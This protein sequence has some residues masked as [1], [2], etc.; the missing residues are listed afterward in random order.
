MD[1]CRYQLSGTQ[2]VIKA[3]FNGQSPVFALD[4][5]FFT[6]PVSAIISTHFSTT[7]PSL[8]RFL[9]RHP[10]PLCIIVRSTHYHSEHLAVH[11]CIS[12][13][14]CAI[15]IG[16][17]VSPG[18]HH[19]SNTHSTLP[20]SLL[21]FSLQSRRR[22]ALLMLLLFRRPRPQATQVCPYSLALSLLLLLLSY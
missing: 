18:A 10:H 7:L 11:V 14:C 6:K 21:S 16:V 13:G 8:H 2:A 22:P 3:R 12:A 15:H 20:S 5:R 19:T 17:C 4:V 1:Y 9:C